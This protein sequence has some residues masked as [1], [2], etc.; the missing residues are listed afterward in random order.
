ML[1][2]FSA[3][4]VAASGLSA[5]RA[6]MNTVAS[7]LANARTTRTADGGPYKRLDPVFQSV[8]L[9][10][11]NLA[12]N[13]VSLVRVRAIQEDT[14]DPMLVHEPGHPDA[15]PQGYVK[16]PNVNVVEE[17]VNM[18]TASR[19]YEAGVTSLESIKTMARSALQI[20]R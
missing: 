20:G 14:R 12:S 13:S 16:Y 6:R 5:E 17:M 8:P 2:T 1:G 11:G 9:V 10:K 4:E 19:A 7:N 3:M 18:M 15:D